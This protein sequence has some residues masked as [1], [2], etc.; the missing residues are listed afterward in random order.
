MLKIIL[1]VSQ[2]TYFIF[3]YFI[4]IENKY[5]TKF[6][7]ILLIHYIYKRWEHI[8]IPKKPC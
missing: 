7:P 1:Y 4:M 3:K 5:N 6:I 8:Y 2:I